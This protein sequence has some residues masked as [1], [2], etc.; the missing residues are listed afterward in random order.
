MGREVSPGWLRAVHAIR[1]SK[2]RFETSQ[3]DRDFE[4]FPHSRHWIVNLTCGVLLRTLCSMPCLK[5]CSDLP[6]RFLPYPFLVIA[7]IL[8]HFNGTRPV[9]SIYPGNTLVAHILHHY[10]TRAIL[11][12]QCPQLLF[13]GNVEIDFYD[14][15]SN[16]N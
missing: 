14:S 5:S 3:T 10:C 12:T 6:C 7:S 13:R 11:D 8:E 16:K 4:R 1:Q 9:S 2:T 15:L